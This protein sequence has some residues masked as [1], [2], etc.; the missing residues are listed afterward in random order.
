[1]R[2]IPERIAA[3]LGRGAAGLCHVWIMTR[4]DA[5]RLG[6]TDHDAAVRFLGVDCL[7]AS[8]LTQGAASEAL[9][10]EASD[11]SV[12]GVLTAE[13]LRAEDIEA[14]LYDG[15]RLDTYVVSWVQTE[16]YLHLA[17][18]TLA[19]LECRGQASFIA[20]VEGPA[21]RLRQIVG[22]RFTPLCEA[23]LGDMRCGVAAEV[24]VVCDKRYA[25]CRGVFGNEINF[26]G[27][28]DMPGED[29]ISLYPRAG[30]LMNGRS[31]GHRV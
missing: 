19:R 25:T 5:Q 27:F 14:G 11:S 9:G 22:R 8:G 7:A 30:D 15:A 28:P 3:A 13:A 23:A 12:S 10:S 4:K 29:F 2:Q 18:G 6:F 16:D 24:G 17:S 26:R 20:H 1:M 31:S 21:A